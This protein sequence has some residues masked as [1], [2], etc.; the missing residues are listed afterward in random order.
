[1]WRAKK[2]LSA[3]YM[4]LNGIENFF[5][6]QVIN[7]FEAILIWF[8]QPYLREELYEYHFPPTDKRL[9]L[10]G[11]DVLLQEFSVVV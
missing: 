1:M 3:F 5:I 8:P 4:F 6:G 11:C 10:S 9:D 7:Y 2:Q